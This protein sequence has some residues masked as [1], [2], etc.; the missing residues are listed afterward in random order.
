MKTRKFNNKFN[1]KG[2]GF[3]DIFRSKKTNTIPFSTPL[4]SS[5]PIKPSVK[6]ESLKKTVINSDKVAEPILKGIDVVEKIDENSGIISKISNISSD[7]SVVINPL[8][9]VVHSVIEIIRIHPIG[10]L[11]VGTLLFVKKLKDLYRNHQQIVE[12]L[13][14]VETI[15]EN[16]YRLNVLID[17]INE[18]MIIY[19]FNNEEYKNKYKELFELEKNI[20]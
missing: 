1:N 14:Q 18:T 8:Q 19:T 4:T 2:G 17:K 5:A 10:H 13:T 3:F 7:L 12:F 15:V 11:L 16:S 6:N 9:S 20:K